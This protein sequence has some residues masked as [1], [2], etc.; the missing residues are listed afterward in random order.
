M[1]ICFSKIQNR[2]LFTLVMFHPH[3]IW[4]IIAY[5]LGNLRDMI[6]DIFGDGGRTAKVSH[7]YFN[8][9]PTTSAYL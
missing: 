8:F 7:K 9:S 4:I 3:Q 5:L 6:F 2:D 1:I